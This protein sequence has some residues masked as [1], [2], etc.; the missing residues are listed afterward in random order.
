LGE[1]EPIQRVEKDCD[2]IIYSS[3][4]EESEAESSEKSKSELALKFDNMADKINLHSS[5]FGDK[6]PLKDES[7]GDVTEGVDSASELIGNSHMAGF[8]TFHINKPK[9]VQAGTEAV[10]FAVDDPDASYIGPGGGKH[11][12]GEG[13]NDSDDE[14]TRPNFKDDDD[15]ATYGQPPK[16]VETAE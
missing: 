3:A 11:N 12:K 16:R 10:P 5:A 1:P 14:T 2:C 6:M 15:P 7:V 9:A 8:T 4:D 13:A